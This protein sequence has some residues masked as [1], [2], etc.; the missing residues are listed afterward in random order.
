MNTIREACMDIICIL[1]SSY[2]EIFTC[3]SDEHFCFILIEKKCLY[4]SRFFFFPFKRK[5]TKKKKQTT[6]QACAWLIH[7]APFFLRTHTQTHYRTISHN[8]FDILTRITKFSLAKSNFIQ[9]MIHA[10]SLA[11]ENQFT[12]SAREG[13]RE[14]EKRR[15]RANAKSSMVGVRW[16]AKREKWKF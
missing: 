15:A 1:Q 6:I 3:A 12:V 9:V 11:V 8:I 10:P 14:Q 2:L 5:K 4:R 16:L 13:E 7:L